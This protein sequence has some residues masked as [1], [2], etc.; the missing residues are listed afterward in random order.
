VK[1]IEVQELSALEWR[2]ASTVP[3]G[4]K[5]LFAVF[6]PFRLKEKGDG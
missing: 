1:A 3:T 4:K 5:N 2:K 6:Y